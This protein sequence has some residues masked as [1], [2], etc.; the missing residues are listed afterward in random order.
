MYL[1]SVRIVKKL[2]NN[3]LVMSTTFE[4]YIKQRLM[5]EFVGGECRIAIRC[6][7][8]MKICEHRNNAAIE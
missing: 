8:A 5:V 3:S 1:E 2:N 6:T 4:F 7:Q